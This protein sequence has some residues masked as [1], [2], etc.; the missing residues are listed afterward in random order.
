ME[1]PYKNQKPW[2][3]EV[4]DYNKGKEIE[5]GKDKKQTEEAKLGIKEEVRRFM[6]GPK[7]ARIQEYSNRALD[8]GMK[9]LAEE[10]RQRFE[11][12]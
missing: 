12:K 7:Q 8:I 4:A 9:D 11:E 1:N 3:Q 10:R 6:K 5:R 2:E